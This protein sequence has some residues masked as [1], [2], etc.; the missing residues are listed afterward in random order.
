MGRK[1]K[2]NK[3]TKRCDDSYRRAPRLLKEMKTRRI[4]WGVRTRE[5]RGLGGLTG[6]WQAG[7]VLSV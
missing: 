1:E 6:N 4:F 2:R 5:G 3:E 7:K